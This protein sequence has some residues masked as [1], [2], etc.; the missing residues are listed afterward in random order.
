MNHSG[1]TPSVVLECISYHHFLA[2]LILY[3]WIHS[4]DCSAS[5]FFLVVL[6][7]TKAPIDF[8]TLFLQVVS[9]M[10]TAVE[11]LVTGETMQISTSREQRR[12]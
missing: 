1:S 4:C 6:Y 9:L 3:F 8:S 11:H 5:P 7:P 12:R 2:K 10:A